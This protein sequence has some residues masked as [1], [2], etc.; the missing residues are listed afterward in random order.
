[1]ARHGT[2]QLTDSTGAFLLETFSITQQAPTTTTTT[3]T[4]QTNPAGLNFSV[5]GGSLQKAPGQVSLQSGPHTIAVPSPQAGA[6]GTQY[7]WTS[8][9]DQGA[10]SHS[11]TVGSTPATYTATFATQYQLTTS[12]SPPAGGTVTPASGSFYASGTAV[13]LAAT[14]SAGFTFD[15][16]TGAVASPS[17]A[18]T[19]VTMSAPQ[20]VVANFVSSPVI[21]TIQTNPTGLKF[22]VDS[23]APQVS[24]Q[25]LALAPGAHTIAVVT[26]QPGAA[27][28]TSTRSRHGAIRAR[29]PIPSRWAITPRPTRP[30]SRFNIS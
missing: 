25:K 11:I 7:L 22:S 3:I 17:A 23:S 16:W 10:P 26:T 5:D 18:S 24:P 2:I 14:A 27:G 13:P 29:L 21:I 19:T 1:M 6:A 28:D 15:K 9:S 30:I 8:W 4:I 20:T 12:A